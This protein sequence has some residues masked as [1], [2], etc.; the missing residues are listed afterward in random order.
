MIATVMQ[1]AHCLLD[2]R[3]GVNF[4][5]SSMI[6][7]N[8][9]YHIKQDG[10]PTLCTT[11]KQPMLLYKLILLNLDTGNLSTCVWFGIAAQLAVDILLCTAF[12]D[13]FIRGFFSS[14]QKVVAWNSGSI[15]ITARPNMPYNAQ[16]MDLIADSPVSGAYQNRPKTDLVYEVVWVAKPI[17]L[18]P[19]TQHRFLAHM[20]SYGLFTIESIDHSRHKTLAARGVMKVYPDNRFILL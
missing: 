5:R 17:E 16:S 7:T 4:I 9:G 15:A 13:R 18:Q 6:P 19:Y 14:E 2:R 8:R 20:Q 11:T 12:N 3:A 10:I 1:N